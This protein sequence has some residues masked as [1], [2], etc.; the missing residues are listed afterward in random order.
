MELVLLGRFG[1][2]EIRVV[3]GPHDRAKSEGWRAMAGLLL[4]RIRSST[5]SLPASRRAAQGCRPPFAWLANAKSGPAAR[6]RH[7]PMD[8]DR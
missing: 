4:Q 1:K 8:R 3:A 2:H 6:F 5:E 7:D